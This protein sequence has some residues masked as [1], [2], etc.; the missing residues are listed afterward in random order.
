[1]SKNHIDNF[2][3]LMVFLAALLIFFHLLYNLSHPV[4]TTDCAKKYNCNHKP[5]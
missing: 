5:Q 4:K 2:L 1:M 3:K